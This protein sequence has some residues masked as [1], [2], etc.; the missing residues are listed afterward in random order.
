MA[1]VFERAKS[2]EADA[3]VEAIRKTRF[4]DNLMVAAGPVIFNEIGDNPNASTAMIQVLGGKPVL[5]WPREAAAQKYLF[6][7][8]RR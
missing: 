4:T 7:R 6:P 5:V 2:T 8:S 3:V 1:D